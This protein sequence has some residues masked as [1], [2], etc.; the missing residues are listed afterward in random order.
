MKKSREII[1][2]GLI[3]LLS[4]PSLN[5]IVSTN[6][7]SEE[8]IAHYLAADR[9]LRQGELELAQYEV[10]SAVE[11]DTTS[12]YLWRKLME[13]SYLRGDYARSE[14]AAQEILRIG[15]N[16]TETL[17]SLATLY[18]EQGE[19]QVA[20]STYLRIISIEPK[21]VK[22][23]LNLARVYISMDEQ[24][25]A[26]S[27]LKHCLSIEPKNIVVH[28]SMGLIYEAQDSKSEA[29]KVYIE[30]ARLAPDNSEVAA[31]L[32]SLYWRQKDLPKA[33]KWLEKA[34]ELDRQDMESLYNLALL[35]E[36]QQEWDGAIEYFGRL[37]S[38]MEAE[39]TTNWD[40][41]IHLGFDYVEKGELEEAASHLKRATEIAPDEPYG[42]YLLGLVEED[43]KKY[44]EAS[45]SFK[46][47]V[48]LKHDDA[49]A[50]FHLGVCLDQ[51][52]KTKEAWA[53]FEHAIRI[54]EKHAQAL[55]YL[56]YSWAERGINLERAEEL[57]KRAL[58][59]DAENPAYIDS[60][61]WVY[62]QQKKYDQARLL[63]EKA[64]KSTADAIIFEHLG[65]T[66]LKLGK[67]KQAVSMYR[68]AL[69]LSPDNQKLKAKIKQAR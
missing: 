12:V 63:L 58:L 14:E 32:G 47:V 31:R 27:T 36:E 34:V 45:R 51:L 22:A 2:I 16:D 15:G 66:Y 7:F 69:S 61:G 37:L 17:E 55:N 40:I 11:L 52:G 19:L 49:N 28:L 35:A 20:A 41:Y 23:Y 65:D 30:A 9:L 3:L 8:A 38:I 39:S 24:D 18:L 67:R 21:N 60:M 56:G 44:N 53:E 50:H 6:T 25:R 54:D 29:E 4:I 13:F 59:I 62:Y 26:I 43:Q 10:E 57:I 42:W 48:E 68:K 33:R 64:S 1:L 46:K 5:A